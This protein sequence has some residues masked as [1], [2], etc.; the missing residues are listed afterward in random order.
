ML[1]YAVAGGKP[2]WAELCAYA[3]TLSPIGCPVDRYLAT[4]RDGI[5]AIHP[6]GP[7]GRYGDTYLEGRPTGEMELS[8][9]PVWIADG[10]TQKTLI[11]RDITTGV[12]RWWLVIQAR[13]GHR[14]APGMYAIEGPRSPTSQ[15]EATPPEA[16]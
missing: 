5:I 14:I 10:T 8:G 13:H 1:I 3:R 11:A 4:N 6:L 12:E 2:D 9:P 16:N 7:W 15:S